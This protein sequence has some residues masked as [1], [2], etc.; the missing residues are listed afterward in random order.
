[1][2]RTFKIIFS[3]SRGANV[4]AS[5][6]ASSVQ[7][8]GTKLVLAAAVAAAFA[9]GAVLAEEFSYEQSSG[10]SGYLATTAEETSRTFAEGD[11][12]KMTITGDETRAYGLLA[13]GDS[14][15]FAN[16]GTID[17]N[18]ATENVADSWKVK[19]M[20]A[21]AGGTAVNYGTINVLKAYGMTVGSTA[22][23]EN[24]SNTI[25]NEGVINV[26]SGAGMEG[27]PTGAAGTTG[28]ARAVV[29]NN[30][31]INVESG[32]GLLVSGSNGTIANNG[33]I[34]ADGLI[35]VLVQAE[36]GKT[37]QGNVITFGAESSTSGTVQIN[38]SVQGTR[39]TF[40][41]GALLDGRIVDN[42]TGTVIEG[43][44]DISGQ[45]EQEVG[46]G[47]YL[48]A[49][50]SLNLKDSTFANNQVAGA[51]VYGGA[52]H[53]YG[54]P[55]VLT[56]TVFEGNSAVSTGAN[57]GSNG[58]QK[59]AAGGAVM[60]KGNA[61]TVFTD[62]VFTN[63]SAAAEKTD[64]TT[65]GYAY[66]GALM[67]DYSTGTATGVERASDVTFKITKDLLYTG[68]TVSSD[69]TAE[70]F[71][72]YG[73][74]VPT[75]QAGGFLF[76]DRGSVAQFDVDE[77]R[78][79]T[80]GS[81][82]TNDD[83]DGI[84]SSI[85]NTNTDNNGGRHADITKT[86]LGSVVING[87][88]QK[89][90]GTMTVEAGSLSVNSDWTLKNAVTV[91]EGAVLALAS[92][93]LA[94]ADESGNQDVS[95]SKLAGTL[96]V[97]G[98]LQT[99]S[100]QIFTQAASET[101]T[102]AGALVHST[103]QLAVTGTIALNDAAY[104]LDYAQSV[105]DVFK[106][107]YAES[108]RVEL[109]GQ[110]VGQNDSTLT[111]DEVENIA[112][113]VMLN[114]VTIASEDKNLQIG[115]TVPSDLTTTAYRANGL[116]VGDLDLGSANIVT[117]DGGETLSLAGQG[118]ELIATTAQ[119]G[120]QVTVQ[121]GSQLALGASSSQGGRISGSV[122]LA[123][124][125]SVL[126]VA[127]PA[128][129]EVSAITGE[130]SVM[131][132][133]DSAAGRLN[134]QSLEGFTGTVFV[135]PAW[136]EG[137]NQ[138]TEA[139]SF[140]VY[141]ASS[142]GA[143]IAAGRNSV[144]ALGADG[145]SAASAFEKISAASGLQWGTDVT[146]AA[147]VDKPV[148][149]T[150]T[151]GVVVDGSLTAAPA[152]VTAGTIS[153]ASS[154]MLIANQAAAPADGS[155]LIGGTVALAE[156]SFVGLSNA[157]EGTFKL[158][159]SIS[160]ADL[161]NVSVVTDNPFI[162]AGSAQADGTITAQVDAANG[163]GA[164]ASTGLQ[165]MTRRADT[166]LAQT[167]A[168]R[169]SIDQELA[170]GLNLW[171]DVAGETYKAND[172]DNGGEFEADMGYGTFGGDVGFGS[173]TVGGAFQ[174]GTGSLRSSVSNIKNDIDNY[175]VSLYGTYKATDALK[176]AAELAYVWGEND[177]TSSQAALNQSV[178][179]E[180]YS[181]GLRAMYE[182]KAGNFSFVPS[183][184]VR[185][186]QL[187]TDAMQVGAVKVE[188]QDQTLVQVPLALRVNASEFDAGGWSVAPSFKIAYV[189]TFGDKDIE[190]LS[191]T[192]DVIDTSPV[193]ADFGLRVG[194]DNML[195]NVNM[196]LGAGEYGSSA[197]GGKVGFKYAF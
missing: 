94:S 134:V 183:V 196:L 83:T 101:Q 11:V 184:G 189:P 174:Y 42:G 56:S 159:D 10:N 116:S 60:L 49:G 104:T 51:D 180:M 117:V 16:R 162:S 45:G 158:A 63:N 68:N 98:T 57:V 61:D 24:V 142:L 161:A 87:S 37:T 39:I 59:G 109:L 23:S 78:T 86:G 75:A 81:A 125:A 167:I 20:M 7:K 122:A 4:V 155:A 89:Y 21:D 177:I 93:D 136:G 157:A 99:S 168:D 192:Q 144:V 111:L 138:V 18:L 103:E 48:G 90:Y 194:K 58:V 129:F 28:T 30:G 32:I 150:G 133:N 29:T 13:S 106:Q 85:P 153:I 178:D 172:L 123:D 72:T 149:F 71:D 195:F 173:F 171:V 19:G 154:G 25:I 54:S 41:D 36:E 80:I 121:N 88:L 64:D 67:V 145:A 118:G 27:A 55:V 186:S 73:Y 38:K 163:L 43:S 141:E 26:Q 12:L 120:V 182:I 95:G 139:S 76:L 124:A 47:I 69:S 35:A 190:V 74:H 135:D 33:T 40:A 126:S 197:V 169:T 6:A 160:G 82:V 131:V 105:G 165:A 17:L 53:S 3:K 113:E 31:T 193:Q 14:H 100:G 46:A 166:V 112:P 175:A 34:N 128:G 127:G 179:T 52:I 156:G 147:Y 2:N 96:T 146:A 1:M 151:G 79:L 62:V 66:G 44:V 119:E 181:F 140:G 148:S 107:A 15:Q 185:V 170:A 70:S 65:G 114:T 137:V 92:F 102:S 164:L 50:S 91:G 188:D 110:L 84:A 152:A 108:G 187:S 9:S 77:G 22:G 176:L 191:R 132:G 97:A 115:G 143:Q 8:K 130:G 5:E